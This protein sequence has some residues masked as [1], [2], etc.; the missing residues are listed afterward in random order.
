MLTVCAHNVT[1]LDSSLWEPY[2]KISVAAQTQIQTCTLPAVDEDDNFADWKGGGLGYCCYFAGVSAGTAVNVQVWDADSNND[3]LIA[4]RHGVLFTG[5][6]TL[7]ED[8]G[9]CCNGNL[10]LEV[11]WQLSTPPLRPLWL[12]LSRAMTHGARSASVPELEPL[13]QSLPEASGTLLV[14]L[15]PQGS[16]LQHSPLAPSRCGASSGQQPMPAR[17]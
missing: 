7:L 8:D 16:W 5:R 15:A 1:D 4:F 13:S 12:R 2:A 3:D 10:Y 14:A 11:N 6:Y 17:E 9:D